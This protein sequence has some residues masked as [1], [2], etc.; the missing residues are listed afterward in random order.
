MLLMST[1]YAIVL[2]MAHEAPRDI[3]ELTESFIAE[4]TA[5]DAARDYYATDGIDPRI[6][7]PLIG[8][9]ENSGRTPDSPEE[10]VAIDLYEDRFEIY[11]GLAAKEFLTVNNFHLRWVDV[12][13]MNLSNH[14]DTA[15]IHGP[16]LNH[17]VLNIRLNTSGLDRGGNPTGDKRPKLHIEKVA[18]MRGERKR[19]LLTEYDR[20]TVAEAIARLGKIKDALNE[21]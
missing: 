9:D 4:T 7:L 13:V 21:L 17:I 5:Y 1:K 3:R 6:L 18:H 19:I 2:R 10:K 14:S 11:N 8:S 16:R 20:G 12:G 15:N